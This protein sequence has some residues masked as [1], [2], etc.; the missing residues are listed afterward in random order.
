MEERLFH[1]SSPTVVK[2]VDMYGFFAVFSNHDYFSQ[3]PCNHNHNSFVI[4]NGIAL[5]KMRSAQP[6]VG[7]RRG[8]GK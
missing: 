3:W 6:R 7:V 8:D 1:V 2:S 4:V 5:A